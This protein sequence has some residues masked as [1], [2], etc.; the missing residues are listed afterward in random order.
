MDRR[1][2]GHLGGKVKVNSRSVSTDL[3]RYKG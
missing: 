1:G 2:L 3:G